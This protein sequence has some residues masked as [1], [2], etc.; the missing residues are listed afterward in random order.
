ML[1]KIIGNENTLA[2]SYANEVLRTVIKNCTNFPTNEDVLKGTV[3]V[4][5]QQ[6]SREPAVR[7]KLRGIFANVSSSPSIPPKKDKPVAELRDE[8]Y[9]QYLRLKFRQKRRFS[10]IKLYAD[11]ELETTSNNT[12]LESLFKDTT[13]FHRDEYFYVVEEWN[14]LRKEILR[15]CVNDFLVPVFEREAHERLYEE[16][17]EC[18]LR[19]CSAKLL[20]VLST[21]AY[22]PTFRY[23][24]DE[25]DVEDTG[26]RVMAICYSPDRAEA[27]FAL[28]I[29]QDGMVI[30]YLRL[31]HFN[32]RMFSRIVE[33]ANL[34]KED[35][36]NL[37]KL[38]L[39]RQP[40]I[41]GINGED[42]EAVRLA[43]DVKKLVTTMMTE[44]D[45]LRNEI[46]VEITENDAA[47]V[48][49]SSRN[50]MQEYPEYPPLLR[51]AVS[52]ARFVLDPLI[53]I[54][55]L[56]NSDEDVLFMKFHPLQSELPKRDLLFALQL[57]CINRVNEVGV[58][59]N[60]CLEFPH[61][62][63]L[64]Q[65]V[66]GLGPRKASH[67]LKILKQNDNLLESRTKLVTFC[68]MGPK[69]F[70]NA[71]GFI[72]I[73]TAR[74]SERTD[75]YVEVLDG[76]RV[77]PE[78][79]EWAR[80]MAVDALEIDDPA[81]PTGALEEICRL[82][83]L[84]LDAFAEELARQGFGNKSITLY[85][86]RAEL[87]YRY[88]DLR[89]P[90]KTPQG[91]DLYEILVK[92]GD[93][94][95]EGKLVNG[96]ILF[97]VHRKPGEK[98]TA[99]RQ[100]KHNN[101]RNTWE[102]DFC[103]RD[104]FT[105][106]SQVWSHTDNKECQGIPVG[107]KVRLDNGILGFVGLKNISDTPDSF[108][109]PAQ[110]LVPGRDQVFRVMSFNTEKMQCELSC[111][112]SDLQRSNVSEKD[113]HFDEQRCKKDK[114]QKQKE[115][116]AQTAKNQF[117]KRVISHPSFHNVTFKDAERMLRGMDPGDAIVRP[118]GSSAKQEENKERVF[119]IGKILFINNEPYEDLDE[120]IARYIQPMAGF[121][122]DIMTYKYYMD[123]VYSEDTP[124]I[125][126][127]LVSEKQRTPS[128]IP[129]TLT[130][131]QKYPAKFVL[132]YLAQQKVRHEY[133]SATPEGIKFATKCSTQR[134]N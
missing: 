122:R 49:M 93:V 66:C 19:K 43:D 67:L 34:K 1:T 69:V 47:K 82:K 102:C 131:S 51:Q 9:L 86:I 36:N 106:I 134:R 54:S 21:E 16:A 27:S 61:T 52:L 2:N 108:R 94:C 110:R 13:I 84:D 115:R 113:N 91:K 57:E 32:K 70:M 37:R 29:D 76:S 97:V 42:L 41:I 18:V 50:A 107:V 23:P 78:T 128:K 101:Q 103:K 105:D 117:V 22:K 116:S 127:H 14:K 5:A 39:R 30:D 35:M 33:E 60:R 124:T 12:M 11:T 125:E 112:T 80:K 85:D 114:E 38:I 129:Y 24:N 95:A 87:N 73:D 130:A 71:S 118:S 77:H 68:R 48:Y 6:F 120:I 62:A 123:G 64:L 8:E 96:R 65:F 132:S 58:D 45:L 88:K 89:A 99:S 3:Y 100:P 104:D 28:V 53:E 59:I 74:V 10:E 109:N 7:K 17:R 79:Y 92:D 46:P 121:A 75:A 4:L 31:V 81:D 44:R 15:M 25:D 133:L 126:A 55:H 83:D 119:D 111:R 56:C 40:H 63:G 90:H 72:K 20:D 98:D 26:V